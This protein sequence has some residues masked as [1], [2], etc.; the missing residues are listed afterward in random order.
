MKEKKIAVLGHFMYGYDDVA[1][2][3]QAVKTHN[4]LE[5]LSKKYGSENISVL[6]TNYFRKKL[7][8]NY[9]KIIRICQKCDAIVIMPTQNGLKLILPV[10][11]LLKKKY[12][13]TIVYPV[14]GGWLPETVDNVRLIRK[15]LHC[16]DAIYL[17]TDQL[18]QELQKRGFSTAKTV[19]NFSLHFGKVCQWKYSEK[20][21]VCRCYTFSRVTKTKGISEAI[22]A[23]CML[24][25]INS[26]THYTLD[27]YGPL[28]EMYA[29][30]LKQK[31]S[32]SEDVHYG[33]VL[34]GDQILP[35]LSAHDLMIFPTYYAG[36]GMP[37]SVIESFLAGVPVIA[38]DWHNNSEVVKNGYTG[39]VYQLGN[40]NILVNA[41]RSVAE[42]PGELDRMHDNCVEE[43]KKYQ[44]MTIMQ[45]VFDDIDNGVKI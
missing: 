32:E 16:V 15:Y 29:I 38:S 27:I 26:G 40:V 42:Q 17:E 28:D 33:G 34:S 44:P 37:G 8:S 45:T 36:E 5:L 1:V 19:A 3:G 20:R 14:I 10:L 18:T 30:E 35:I 31:C 9:R 43:R 6:D 11:H 22:K 7:F 4:Y 25:Q 12:K 41:I 2:N 21:N 23:I 39:V 24:N 13:F